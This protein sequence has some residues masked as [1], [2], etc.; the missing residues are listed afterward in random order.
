[1]CTINK[2]PTSVVKQL[3]VDKLNFVCTIRMFRIERNGLVYR[4]FELV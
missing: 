1:M 2:I 3:I 4:S